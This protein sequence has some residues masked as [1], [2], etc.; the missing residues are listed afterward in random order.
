[1]SP[2]T[3]KRPT[4][5]WE[6]IRL[7]SFLFLRSGDSSL[8]SLGEPVSSFLTQAKAAGA[9]LGVM[10]FSSMPVSRQV[11]LRCLV[12]MVTECRFDLRMVY[13][14]QNRSDSVAPHL[15]RHAADL[16]HSGR[17]LEVE[18]ADFGALF[19]HMDFFVVHGGLGTTLEALRIRAMLRHWA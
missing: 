14:A 15:S 5:W 9:K 13:V 16:E 18:R 7:T 8:A 10:T 17:I 6:S 11:A 1:M 12:K 2:E 3:F 4:D 19:R